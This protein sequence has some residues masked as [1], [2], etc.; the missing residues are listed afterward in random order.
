MDN[1][2]IAR[3]LEQIADLLEIKGENPFKIRAYRTAAETLTHE[4]EPVAALT[5]DA[6]LALPGIGKDLAAKIRELIQTG[7]I[8]YH[9]ELL[10]DIPATLLDVLRLQGVGPKTV[11][12]LYKEIGVRSLDD[13]E[14]AARDGRIRRMS[15]MGLKKEA[16]ILK[17]LEVLG[18]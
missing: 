11:A 13:L 7:A 17:A 16:Q 12:R 3:I 1:Q 6:L 9:Q 8:R 10:Q 15:G 5:P 14:Q 2:G 18:K 4:A